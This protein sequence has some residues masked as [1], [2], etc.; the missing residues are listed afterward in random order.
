MGYRS[1]VSITCDNSAF[2]ELIKRLK[3]DKVNMDY[4][5]ISKPWD[6]LW[7]ITVDNIKWYSYDGIQTTIE[8]WM[9]DCIESSEPLSEGRF[10]GQIHHIRI[11][12]DYDDVEE[13]YYGDWLDDGMYVERYTARPEGGPRVT[14]VCPWGYD[15]G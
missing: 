4:F 15:L 11:G 12:E 10:H 2:S 14:I 3:K 8:D 5:D 13:N 1:D 6:G 7:L 9:N